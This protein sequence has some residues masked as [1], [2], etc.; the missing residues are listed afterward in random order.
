[1]RIAV[2]VYG[3]LGRGIETYEN[4]INHIGNEHDINF[5]MSSDN[6]NQIDFDTFIKV[7]K[8]VKYNNDTIIVD[9]SITN[10][11][12]QSLTSYDVSVHNM[13]RHFIN[14][15]RVFS[16]LENYMES[17]KVNFDL[18]ITL[19]IDIVFYDKINF[20]NIE[21]N[22]IYIPEDY[23]FGGIND[24]WAYGAVSTMK[25]YNNIYLS[26]MELI[27][28]KISKVGPEALT[29]ANLQLHKVNIKRVETKCCIIR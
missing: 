16:L 27:E 15:H 21:E 23:D 14:K 24:R 10:K 28:R 2:L 12:I 11:L 19:R 3:R 1:M 8:P 4:F 13:I 7:F 22:T 6:S 5:F 20:P 18:V 17:E 9:D 26:M 29:L 25:K